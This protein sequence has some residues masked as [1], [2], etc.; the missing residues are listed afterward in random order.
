MD[1]ALNNS[2]PN[3][4]AIDLVRIIAAVAVVMIHTD[5]FISISSDVEFYVINILTRFAV[6]FFFSVTGFFFFSKLKY[7]NGKLKKCKENN[8]MFFQF[9]KRILILYTLWSLVY[10]CIYLPSWII[11]GFPFTDLFIDFTL[12]F[13]FRGVHYHFWYL[14]AIIYAIPI[15]YLI[16]RFFKIKFLIIFLIVCY[17][18]SLASSSYS[19]LIEMFTGINLEELRPKNIFTLSLPRGLALIGIGL[20]FSI[21]KI[22]LRKKV[23]IICLIACFIML[24][25]E[26]WINYY[27]FNNTTVSYMIF[28]LPFSIF[29][30][31][32]VL[33]FNLEGN[34]QTYLNLRKISS[35]I[36]FVHPIF[37]VLLNDYITIIHS[38][39]WFIVILILSVISSIIFVKLSQYKKLKF[40]QYLY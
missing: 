32:F 36:Y 35:F 4:N 16:M 26:V 8:K 14:L 38:L 20:V 24:T 34:P 18:I 39:V 19:W 21:K 17:L 5:P 27:F 10:L 31:N 22:I 15:L 40:L 9:M 37:I 25:L 6:P 7:E 23:Q 1:K 12:S 28:T 11:S 2:R 3:Y 29:L 33:N 13:F 30:F